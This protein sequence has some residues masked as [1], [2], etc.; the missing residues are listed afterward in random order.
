MIKKTKFF[1]KF[2]IKKLRKKNGGRKKSLLRK[3][4]KIKNVEIKIQISTPY[5]ISLND[6]LPK[7][8]RN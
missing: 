5:K 7:Y 2:E 1:K 8:K 3:E 6:Y 4:I